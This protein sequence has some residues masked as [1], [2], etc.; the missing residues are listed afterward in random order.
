MLKH[1]NKPNKS[2]QYPPL[3]S[4]NFDGGLLRPSLTLYDVPWLHWSFSAANSDADLREDVSVGDGAQNLTS[5]CRFGNRM[6]SDEVGQFISC[7][8][9]L[10]DLKSKKVVIE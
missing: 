8:N 9:C 1:S 4:I 3:K 2:K 6:K 10:K 7:V 5:L